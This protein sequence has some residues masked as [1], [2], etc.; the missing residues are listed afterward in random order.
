MHFSRFHLLP[1]AICVFLGEHLKKTSRNPFQ[2]KALDSEGKDDEIL[3]SDLKFTNFHF[4][5]ISKNRGFSPKMDGENSGKP[6]KNGM[7]WR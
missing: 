4:M 7:I 6:Y 5:D 3:V 1:Y 2:T